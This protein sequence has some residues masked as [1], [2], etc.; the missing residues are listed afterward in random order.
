MSERILAFESSWRLRWRSPGAPSRRRRAAPSTRDGRH[1]RRVGWQHP[2]T[3]WGDP[4][5]QGMWPIINLISTPF[6]R[7]VDQQGNPIYGDRAELTDE[8]YAATQQR[9]AA[10]DERYQEEIKSNKMGMGHWAEASHNNDAARLDVVARRAEERPLPRAHRARQG[11]RV[12]DEAAAGAPRCST[13]RRISTRGIAASRAVCRRRCSRSTTTTASRSTRR[14]GYVV[15][16][17][18]MIH[19]A[20]VIPVDG[21]AALD[22][23]IK[24]WM[25]E[26][27]G[28]FEGNTLV[29]ETT[30]FNGVGGMTNVGIPGSPRG[31]TPTTT[32]MKITERFTRTDDDTI[33]YEMSVEDPE[34]LTQPW[35]ARYPM[36]RDDSY[37]FFEYACHEDNT[38]VRNFIVTSRYERAQAA[39]RNEQR[40]NAAGRAGLSG[41]RGTVCFAARRTR[42]SA[43]PSRSMRAAS[44]TAPSRRRAFACS[45]AFRSRR[46]RSAR[47]AGARRSRSRSG[48]A[49]A[50]RASSATSAFSR[51]GRPTGPEARLNIAV[52]PDSPPLSRG[53]PLSERLDRCG[54]PRPSAGPCMVYF[55]GGAFTEGSGSVPLYDG[56][57]LARKGAVVVT[58]NY[59]LG[60]YGFFVHPALTAESPH[61][62]SGN[63]GL[64]DML[65]SLRWVQSNIAAFGGDPE[66]RHGVRSVGRCD[67]DRVARRVARSEGPH[68]SR[69]LA[70][71]RVDGPR[72]VGRACARA[73]R[74]RKSGS[75]RRPRPASRRS[76]SCARC[77]RPTSPRSSAAPA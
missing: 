7:P 23:A 16:R 37:Q 73:R 17:L 33:Q 50:T 36:Q 45:R 55:F 71:R 63:Y 5:L 6:Q 29:V 15:V 13:S 67:G 31:D 19:E 10:R 69:D 59:R 40:M 53:L 20:R 64:M 61:K 70:E 27:R 4:D 54:E 1:D 38:A 47:C 48:T 28:H 66:Q 12:E 9:L 52:L 14:P 72:S 44:A 32:N 26:S 74:P 56:D 35:K 8:E 77:R 75:R 43:S 34:V 49:C 22:P 57:A 60:P 58:M 11:A 2:R 18:E 46:R 25:G 51:P 21:R 42:S 3:A 76:S 30:N 24:Q 41:S 68:A 39:K 62:A 65:A